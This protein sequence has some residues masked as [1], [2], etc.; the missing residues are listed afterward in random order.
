M[1]T[2]EVS[3]TVSVPVPAR[4]VRDS[5]TFDD[6]D[7]KSW[8]P[9][10]IDIET[11]NALCTTGG[12]VWNAAHRLHDFLGAPGQASTLGL[13][14]PGKKEG[15]LSPNKGFRSNLNMHRKQGRIPP[16]TVLPK[17]DGE[18]DCECKMLPSQFEPCNLLSVHRQRRSE[19]QSERIFQRTMALS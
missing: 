15:L 9:P 5:G 3:S 6:G 2:A 18:W 17:G 10:L 16:M 12:H 19:I 7:P 1:G 11:T 13:T 4:R 8:G 14:R